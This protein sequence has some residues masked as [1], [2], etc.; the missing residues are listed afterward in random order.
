MLDQVDNTEWLIIYI[1]WIVL[2]TILTILFI[3]ENT[4]EWH[5]SEPVIKAIR[6]ADLV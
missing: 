5:V 2:P 6:G 1:T 4:P 3:A